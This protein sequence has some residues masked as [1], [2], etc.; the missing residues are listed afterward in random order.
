LEDFNHGRYSYPDFPTNTLFQIADFGSADS[1]Y[2]SR[3]YS[4]SVLGCGKHHSFCTDIYQWI[5]D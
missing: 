3:T 4:Y 5:E 1:V 2:N